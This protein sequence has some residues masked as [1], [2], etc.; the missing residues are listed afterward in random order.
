MYPVVVHTM[1]EKGPD[2][3]QDQ[4]TTDGET[5]EPPGTI[6]RSVLGLTGH[7]IPANLRLNLTIGKLYFVLFIAPIHPSTQ[8]PAT[9]P[10]MILKSV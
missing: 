2:Q 5:Y 10:E 7:L 3:R 4:E 8:S 1:S 9:M 6:L